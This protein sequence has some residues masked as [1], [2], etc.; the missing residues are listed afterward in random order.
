MAG[1][2]P[3]ACSHTPV[4]DG[5]HAAAAFAR[6]RFDLALSVR[7]FDVGEACQHHPIVVPKSIGWRR[8]EASRSGSG[9]R[10]ERVQ[11]L[12]DDILALQAGGLRDQ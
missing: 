10:F 9:K 11:S 7:R 3:R 12:A 4:E 5:Q 8:A 6:P 1:G 2:A